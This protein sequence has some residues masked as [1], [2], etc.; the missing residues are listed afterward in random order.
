M[1]GN[2]IQLQTLL[3]LALLSLA[4]SAAFS[5]SDLSDKRALDHTD[6]DRWNRITNRQISN[7]GKW[8][9]YSCLLYTSDAADE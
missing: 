6:Y 7:N 3:I 5:Q 8:I 2:R 4:T 1:F 9:L